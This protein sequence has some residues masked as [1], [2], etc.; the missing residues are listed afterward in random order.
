MRR[1]L[2]A[3]AALSCAA[4]I[5]LALGGCRGDDGG[6]GGRREGARAG[7]DARQADSAL[8]VAMSDSASWPSY[9]RDHTNQR[10]SPLTQIGTANVTGLQL[11]WKYNTG[12]PRAFEASP[13][14]VNGTMYVSTPLNHV[15][16]LDARTGQKKWEYAAEL[17]TTVHC[18]GPV[19]RGVAVYGGRVY[20]GQLDGKLV[21]LDTADG[22]VEWSEQVGNPQEGYALNGPIVAADG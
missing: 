18:C 21:A 17:G 2:V 4:A 13:V 19:N 14:V 8:R 6:Q 22:S 20:M 3:V 9:G 16:A 1:R 5:G 15:V 12:I 11:A 10:W 7:S